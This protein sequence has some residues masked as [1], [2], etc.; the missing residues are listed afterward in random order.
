M[1]WWLPEYYTKDFQET[2]EMAKAGSRNPA[3]FG[4]WSGHK[5]STITWEE[6][7]I[8]DWLD[9]HEIEAYHNYR[10]K[11]DTPGGKTVVT[12][13]PRKISWLELD[14]YLPRYGVGISVNPAFHSKLGHPATYEVAQRDVFREEFMR[15]HGIELIVIDTSPDPEQLALEITRKL[16]PLTRY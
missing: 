6:W 13:Y 10:I 2:L 8:K 5:Q 14:F 11:Y 1:S 7:V 9:R 15:Q 16:G 4:R 12:G 3:A